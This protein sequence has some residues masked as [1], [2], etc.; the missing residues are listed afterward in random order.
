MWIATYAEIRTIFH[1]SVGD[2]CHKVTLPFKGSPA[3]ISG[4]SHFSFQNS[5]FRRILGVVSL[6]ALTILLN[7]YAISLNLPGS[8][9]FLQF[10]IDYSERQSYFWKKKDSV[11]ESVVN[12]VTI[13]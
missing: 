9:N 11:V 1:K 5:L 13:S 7:Y 8:C 4:L 3:L 12:C 2:K 10:K 6:V